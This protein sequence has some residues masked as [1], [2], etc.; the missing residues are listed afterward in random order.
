MGKAEAKPISSVAADGQVMG[1]AALYP[2]YVP[3]HTS[4]FPRHKSAPGDASIAA[5]ENQEG[6]GRPDAPVAPA[7]RMQKIMPQVRRDNGTPCAM[8]YGLYAL[9]PESGLVSLRRLPVCTGRLDP[10]VGRSGPRDFA[11]PPPH[12]P[13]CA[14]AAS[15]AP[16]LACRDD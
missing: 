1:F 15:I 9:S 8:V 6:A 4:A 11:R 16:R 2:S 14:T 12:R 10:S 7:A 5:L 3:C 13:S